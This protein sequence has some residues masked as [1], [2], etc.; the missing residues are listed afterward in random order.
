MLKEQ[1]G[2]TETILKETQTQHT[3]KYNWFLPHNR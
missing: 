1:K 3:Q 2:T